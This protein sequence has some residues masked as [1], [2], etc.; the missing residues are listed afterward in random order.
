MIYGAFVVAGLFS[1]VRYEGLLIL[2][3]MTAM[4]F[5]R[6]RFSK[7]TITRYAIAIGL[8]LLILLPMAHI[9]T[10]TLGYDGLISNIIAGPKYIE[11]TVSGD[12]AHWDNLEMV[13]ASGTEKTFYFIQNG[14]QNLVKNLGKSLIPTFS[15]LTPIGIFFLFRK[16]LRKCGIY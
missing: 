15:F 3:P 1:L 10:E 9:R 6:F 5:Y 12:E 13:Q 16:R 14:V 2:I 7:I 8:I 4:F 11:N